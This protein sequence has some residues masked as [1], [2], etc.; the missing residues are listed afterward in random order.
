VVD[1]VVVGGQ[2]IAVDRADA[3]AA[4]IGD[5]VSDEASVMAATAEE[6]V[7]GSAAAV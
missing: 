3:G 7:S 5:R 4:G 6:T 1:E 2:I